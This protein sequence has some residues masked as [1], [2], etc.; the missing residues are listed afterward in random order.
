[1]YVSTCPV[2]CVV[3][4]EKPE[5]INL[6][7]MGKV[8]KL[9]YNCFAEFVDKFGQMPQFNNRKSQKFSSKK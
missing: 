8:A 9:E 4:S 1:V 6:R 7:R 2:K 3:D 5:A